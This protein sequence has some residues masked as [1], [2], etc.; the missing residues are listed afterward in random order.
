[1]LFQPYS[2]HSDL[3]FFFHFGGSFHMPNFSN[4]NHIYDF[5]IDIVFINLL[6][7]RISLQTQA[8]SLDRWIYWARWQNSSP[9]TRICVQMWVFKLVFNRQLKFYSDFTEADLLRYKADK[10]KHETDYH[11]WARRPLP[12]SLLKYASFDVAAM[13]PLSH[14]FL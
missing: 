6:S 8:G 10:G 2:F 5:S 11:V 4:T 3:F 12:D 13:R 7:C 14:N 9:R 1:M